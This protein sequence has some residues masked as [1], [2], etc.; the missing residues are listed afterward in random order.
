MKL[1]SSALNRNPWFFPSLVLYSLVAIFPISSAYAVPSAPAGLS[2]IAGNGEAT[3]TWSA[4]SGATWYLLYRAP[5]SGGP[6][7][8]VAQTQGVSHT[9]RGLGNGTPHYYRV[10]ALDSSGQSG[11]SSETV[12]TPTASVLPAP[13]GVTVT[14]GNTQATLTWLPVTSAVKYNIYRST[15]PG[16][17]YTLLVPEAPGP[18][19]TDTGLTNGTLYYYVVQTLSTDGGAYSEEVSVTP[20]SQLPPAPTNLVATPGSTWARLTWNAS[21]GATRYAVFRGTAVGGPYALAGY[22]PTTEYEEA[23][24]GNGT[25][26][27]YVV[28]GVNEFGRGAF[29]VEQ[30]A[31]V[32]EIERPHAPV[33]QASLSGSGQIYLSWD[34]A[35]GAVSYILRRATTPGDYTSLGTRSSGYTDSGLVNGTTYYYVVDALNASSYVTRSN[36]VALAPV[37]GGVP[38]APGNVAAIA[39]NTQVTVTWNPVPGAT[40]YQVAVSTTPGGQDIGAYQ[41]QAG[42]S[43]T[44]TGLTNGVTYYFRV[45]ASASYWSTLS[46]EVSATPLDTLLPAPPQLSRHGGNTQLSLTWQ[47]VPGATGYQVYR[48]IEGSPWPATPAG[49]VTGTLFNDKD[50]TNGTTYQYTVATISAAGAGAWSAPV[51]GRAEADRMTPAPVNVAVIPGNTQATVTWDPVP[52]AT[53]YSVT[54]AS[55]SGGTDIGATR[56]E[57]GTS[58]TISGLTNTETYHFRVQASASYWSAFSDEVSTTLPT[59]LPLAPTGLSVTGGNS[60]LSLTWTKVTGATSYRVY[61]RTEGNPWPVAPAGIVTGTL[62]TD[63]GLTNGTTYQ[64]TVAAVNASGGGAWSPVINGTPVASRKTTAPVNVKVVAGYTQATVSWDPVPGATGYSITVVTSPGGAD[65]GASQYQAGPSCT[66]TGLTN[67]TTYYFRVQA[68]SS[69]WSAYSAEVSATPSVSRLLAPTGLYA[70]SGNTQVTLN[71]TTVPGASSY[72]V[73]RRLAGSAWPAA[74]VASP[75]TNSYTDTGLVNGT[76]YYYVIATSNGAWSGE[77]SSVPANTTPPDTTITATPP[78][79]STSITANF[80]FTASKPGSTFQCQLDGGSYATCSS[81]MSYYGLGAGIHTFSVKA[82]DTVG[83]VDPSPASY[84]WTVNTTTT[85]PT[86]TITIN[87]GATVTD[88]TSVTL[89]LSCSDPDGCSQMQFSNDGSSWTTPQSYGVAKSWTLTAGD[90]TK[91]V[92]VKFKDTLGTWSNVF[93]DTIIFSTA[94]KTLIVNRTGTGSGTVASA[95]AGINCGSVCQNSFASSTLVNLTAVA[96]MGSTFVAWGGD[97]SGVSANTP[98]TVNNAMICTARFDS[99]AAIPSAPTGLSGMPGNGEAT[100]TWSDSTGAAWYLLY[101]ANSS[102][103]PY[104]FVAQTKGVSHTDRGFG[105]GTPYYYVVTALNAAGESGYSNEASVI[106]SFSV[107]P[108]PVNVKAISGN[109]QASLVWDDV[110]SEVVYNIYRSTTPG[111]PYTL[112]VPEA[113]G[114]SFTDTGLTNGTLY[115]YVVQTLS[116]DGGAYSEE[117]S[118]TPSSQLP[119]APTNLV[120]TPGSTWARLTWNA[121]AG[122]TRY[123]VFRGTAVGGPYALAGYTPTTEYEEAGLGNGTTY[124][125]VVAGVNEFGRGA[126]SVEQVAAVSEIERPHAPVLQASL[127]GSGQ[128]YLSWDNAA[129][130]VSYILRRATTPGDYTS[131]GTRSSGYTDSGLVNGTTYYYVVDALNASSYVTRSNVVALAPVAGGVP[132][133]PGNVAAIAGNTQVTV[134]WNPVPGATGYQVAV[135]TTPGGQ[136]IGAYQ[137]QAGPSATVTGL[138]NGVTYYFRV[139]ASASYWSTLSAEVSATP[140]DTLLPAP[141]QLSRHGGNTQLSLTWQPVPGATGYQVYRRIEGSPWPATPAG[142]VTGTLFNDKDLTNGTTYQYT[143]AT[144]SAAGAGAWSAPVSGRAEADR[145]TPAPVNVAV[146]PGN[147]QATVT[148]DPVPGATGYSVTVASTSGGTDIGATRYE[149]GTSCTIS[150][151]TNTETYHFR[152]QASAS[153]WSA[154]SDEVSTT[155]PTTLPLAPTGLSVTGGNS[156]LS[157]TWTKVTGAT[158]YRVYRRTEGNPWP[159]APAGI[160]TG[161]LFTDSGLTNGTTYQYTVAAVN[162]SGGGAW[163]PVING[164]PVASRKTTAPVNVKVVAGYTQ[165]TVSWDPVPG[166]TGYSIT[167]V[168]SPGGADIG[169]SQYQAGPSCTVTGLTNGTTYY[170]RVQAGSSYWSAYSAEVSA[171]PSVSRLLAPT[172][173]YATGGIGEI[174]LEWSAVTGATGYKIYRRTDGTVFKLIDSTLTNSYIDNKALTKDVRFYYVVEAVNLSG[175]GAWSIEAS[176]VPLDV[177]QYTLTVNITGSGSVNNLVQPPVF[178]CSAST[179]SD[180]F[181]SGTS[182]LLRATP[183]SK[184]S[185]GGWSGGCAG[186]GDCSLELAGDTIVTATFTPL[187]LVKVSGNLTPYYTIQSAYD[188]T[189]INAFFSARNFTFIENVIFGKSLSIRFDGGLDSDFSTPNDYTTIDGSLRVRSGKVAVKRLKIR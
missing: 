159:V 188:S 37:A 95:P 173:L 125:Y 71:W 47:P 27:Y 152:V 110:T 88:S 133:A 38:A 155:L 131:L 101:R 2:G 122:A 177:P 180:M 31:A 186:T 167:V 28:A 158:S 117:V 171:T 77:V 18:S 136:D 56:Y 92:S 120:A 118:V 1:F 65:I 112:L 87:S 105:N 123:A 61:R 137:Y 4:S 50:L 121:S 163:S 48:R 82:T 23:G 144:I 43:A 35:A 3:I 127:S 44:V 76:T 187:P 64:Y 62:F 58:C 49:T 143:V 89:A 6:Y 93:S 53:G 74:P 63:S 168:T 12:I 150:G 42:P 146:I 149:N 165:A 151:L 100:L 17:P 138:T 111:G 10:T 114:P 176:A 157:L 147:T 91:T 113:P 174:T 104:E 172:G 132:A 181:Y 126:F 156:Q 7:D 70:A 178:S 40:G 25:T 106:P 184:Y 148:W 52:G 34:N 135:S 161:T 142:T 66:V 124:Y 5:S 134:T 54:V 108:A 46:A 60:Q 78:D 8:F 59:T 32:S 116:T 45:K 21:A 69:Y 145:M 179:C 33:L 99:I 102:G 80:A 79:P 160:V 11:Y 94:P 16:G 103:G 141:P 164:T 182:L 41:Y 84:S 85:V 22:T 55:T 15:T 57:N 83:N 90:G 68:G 169:A 189:A 81:P 14:A 67:G 30:V 183:S 19:F 9:D 175:P 20:S 129:G 130:A 51:S 73:Y 29:S 153:Y 107:L 26:Y 170:F 139:K 96:D 154:F 36:V 24:L 13:T 86:G 98:I 166:A 97:C 128:I 162:A 75:A 72:L 140:L 115:Y 119:P 109:G 185:F 39:G